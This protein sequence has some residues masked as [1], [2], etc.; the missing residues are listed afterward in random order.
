MKDLKWFLPLIATVG[1]L[2]LTG[3]FSRTYKV[4]EPAGTEV[5]VAAPPGQAWVP[6]YYTYA[7]R[8]RVWIPG[9]L[10]ARPSD[11]MKWHPGYFTR[12]RGVY[13]WHDGYWR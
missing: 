3:C 10:E 12:E 5:V 4:Y 6:G 1:A 9:R 2:T 13:V 7:G 11:H 8:E